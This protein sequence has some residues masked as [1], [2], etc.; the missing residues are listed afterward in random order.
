MVVEVF[1]KML[2][3]L[4]AMFMKKLCKIDK[5]VCEKFMVHRARAHGAAECFTNGG[6]EMLMSLMT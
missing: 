3:R 1:C 2:M 6:I 5:K 4:F